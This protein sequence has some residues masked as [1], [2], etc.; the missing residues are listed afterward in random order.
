MKQQFLQ[1]RTDTIRLT[2]YI[3]NRPIVPD[4]SV[5]ITLQNPTGGELQAQASATRDATT[6]EMTYALTTTHTATKGLNFKASWEYTYNGKTYY[7]NNLFDV[8]LSVLSIPIVDEDLYDELS[9][10]RE[11][12][13]QEQGTATAG[14]SGTLTDTGRKE[15][16]DFW[17]GGTI[18][19]IAGT[20]E[21][22]RR[23]VTDYVQSTGVISVTPN[24]VTNPSTDSVYVV[25]RAYTQK[26]K[27]CFEKVETMLYNKG[28]RH[29]LIIESSQI[30]FPLIYLIVHFVCLDL[31]KDPEDKWQVL[32]LKYWELFQSEFN[33]MAVDYDADES[34]TIEEEERQRNLTEIRVN[35]A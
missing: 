18:E 22:Q 25:I 8:V 1:S 2:A 28:Q 4:D 17:T 12:A 7:E 29:S 5:K 19:I 9:S 34:G 15:A 30:K 14:A 31:T 32:A 20:G 35:R 24:W 13:I 11:V 26:I 23:D 21:G 6:G 3:N 33:N 10:L 16:D 27:Q